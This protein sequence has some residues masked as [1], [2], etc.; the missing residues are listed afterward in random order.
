MTRREIGLLPARSAY[1][2][3]VKNVRTNDICLKTPSI[4]APIKYF[5]IQK[6]FFGTHT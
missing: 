3:T 1:K 2:T 5:H 6:G 4:T